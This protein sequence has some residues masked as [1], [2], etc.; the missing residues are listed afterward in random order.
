[1]K[2]FPLAGWTVVAFPAV[3]V[4]QSGPV[5]DQFGH[6]PFVGD[7]PAARPLAAPGHAPRG[8]AQWRALGPFGGDVADVNISPTNP[9]IVLAGIAPS[10]SVGGTLYRS[11]DSG[12]TWTAVPSLAGKSVYDVEFTAAGVVW[13]ATA[14]RSLMRS[15][16]NNSMKKKRIRDQQRTTRERSTIFS[17]PLTLG[18]L[19]FTR[20]SILVR[21][22][23]ALRLA[24]SLAPAA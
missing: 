6:R 22:W 18:F 11:S 19:R 10:G 23:P 17:T 13:V 20:G 1:M 8:G 5:Q 9:A 14:L 7:S 2:L 12:A 3:V 15:A 16:A 4:A 24:S 21:F